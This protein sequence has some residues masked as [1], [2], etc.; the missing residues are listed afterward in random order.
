[1]SVASDTS[2]E[3]LRRE[4]LRRSH[5]LTTSEYNF[6]QGIVANGTEVEVM[7]VQQKL[8]DPSLC[9]DLNADAPM[10]GD[11]DDDNDNI[12]DTGD[13]DDVSVS[14]E[15]EATAE[16]NVGEQEKSVE[17]TISSGT[18]TLSTHSKQMLHMRI[19]GIKS[20]AAAAT[21]TRNPPSVVELL[22][23]TRTFST[24]N[25]ELDGSIDTCAT[26]Q[27]KPPSTPCPV[28]PRQQYTSLSMPSHEELYPDERQLANIQ[29]SD[30]EQTPLV[31]NLRAHKSLEGAAQLPAFSNS[32][33]HANNAK[34][35]EHNDANENT[36]PIRSGRH[37]AG[38]VP[39]TTGGPLIPHQQNNNLA[40]GGALVP[41]PAILR[42]RSSNPLIGQLW[43]AH[44]SGLTVTQQQ[45]SKRAQ[46]LRREQ[47]SLL[48]SNSPLAMTMSPIRRYS[49]LGMNQHRR[50]S[51]SSLHTISGGITPSKACSRSSNSSDHARSLLTPQEL[52]RLKQRYFRTSSQTGAMTTTEMWLQRSNDNNND[53]DQQQQRSML[54][55][56]QNFSTDSSTTD[57]TQ[58][59]NDISSLM[60]PTDEEIFRRTVQLQA[61]IC[62]N[63]TTSIESKQW[64]IASRP[65]PPRPFGGARQ[66]KSTSAVEGSTT[67]VTTTSL[68]PKP[69]KPSTLR[70][71]SSDGATGLPHQYTRRPSALRRMTSDGASRDRSKSVSFHLGQDDKPLPPMSRRHSATT[72]SAIEAAMEAT[73]TTS[74]DFAMSPPTLPISDSIDTME[75]SILS[76]A[77]EYRPPSDIIREKSS[78]STGVPRA[79]FGR[80]DSAT[81]VA[82]L[83]LHRAHPVRQESFGSTAEGWI[84]AR[85]FQRQLDMNDQAWGRRDSMN[86]VASLNLHMARPLRQDSIGSTLEG[87]DA[88][89]AFQM[90]FGADAL[91]SWV[92]RDSMQSLASLNLH[93]ARPLRQDSIASGV[94]DGIDALE[95]FQ[96]Q[97]SSD[98][99]SQ[100]G[101]MESTNSLASLNLHLAAPIQESIFK[102]QQSMNSL[103]SFGGAGMESSEAFR[104]DGWCRRDSMSSLASLN[105]HPA[106]PLRQESFASSVAASRGY[107][108]RDSL[109]SIASLNLHHAQPIRQDSIASNAAGFNALE[110]F[111]ERTSSEAW[112]RQDGALSPAS[113]TLHRAHPVRRDSIA[114]CADG[115]EATEAFR[116][117]FSVEPNTVVKTS[118][119]R[120]DSIGSVAS[121]NLHFGQ[122]LRSDG[123]NLE[124][125]RNQGSAFSEHDLDGDD[126][127]EVSMLSLP[128]AEPLGQDSIVSTST[129]R[130]AKE[131]L[132]L[133]FRD[134]SGD[135]EDAPFGTVLSSTSDMMAIHQRSSLNSIPSLHPARPLRQDSIASTADGREAKEQWRKQ[136]GMATVAASEWVGIISPD[137]WEDKKIETE[138]I[139][140][141]SGRFIPSDQAVTKVNLSRPVI[142]RRA[143]ASEYD[144]EGMEVAALDEENV[145]MFTKTSAPQM[146]L[147]TQ[148]LVPE[149][150]SPPDDEPETF[151][152][153]QREEQKAPETQHRQ[154]SYQH[155]P[156][157]LASFGAGEESF[158]SSK[159][160]NDG[161]SRRR[162][163]IETSA[164]FDESKS[165]DRFRGVFR[166]ELPRSISE[167]ELTALLAAHCSKSRKETMRF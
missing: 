9:F 53:R 45:S 149:P 15:D 143:S 51:N 37:V 97:F 13:D 92:R 32:Y 135:V 99:G 163:S 148:I 4:V 85:A 61:N 71:M 127:G 89:R 107:G 86:S 119:G 136:L 31:Q 114:S 153:C 40:D 122:P 146:Q 22:S 102:R 81:S 158:K 3:G 110:A 73:G 90:D 83:N 109:N 95:A 55:L 130:N 156:D 23:P 24:D 128:P 54:M 1:M 65:P 59:T 134:N 112:G 35:A 56:L 43:R 126:V 120:Q 39:T 88:A 144:E 12:T 129:G 63:A 18:G 121:L 87:A 52:R 58:N 17:S 162:A 76:F 67:T 77:S 57:Y 98:I 138:D 132:Q 78:C 117:E 16:S 47:Q 50:D 75:D 159:A 6:L 14:G 125:L 155:F 34:A 100:Y 42:R 160:I 48:M 139:L 68:D 84:A 166:G 49:S 62:E 38:A 91:A 66:I 79:A 152:T 118:Y 104:P 72:S 123:T 11:D 154:D 28:S 36:T 103:A 80:R 145:E 157:S 29:F 165:I 161:R 141:Q 93:R 133:Q 142:M 2:R 115:L 41:P 124:I 140:T 150:P 108:R 27:G 10:D 30:L 69:L 116:K 151:A 164:S 26:G 7:L 70:R 25:G 96:S 147:K 60:L 8:K 131:A 82:S 21:S 33:Y 20:S 64:E 111:R 137:E 94:V 5:S 167:D 113:L 101:Q 19:N 105:L 74:P 44:E 106:R 46:M